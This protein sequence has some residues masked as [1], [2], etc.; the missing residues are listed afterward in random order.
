LNTRQS[1]A[2]RIGA[3]ALI[4]LT[5]LEILWHAWLAP[6]SPAQTWPSLALAIVPLLPGLLYFRHNLRRG[7]LV[8]GIVCLFYFCHGVSVAYDDPALRL[9]ALAEVALALVV[10]GAL[11]WDARRG[12]RA[13]R[14][15]N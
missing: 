11:G 5:A 8:G 15:E 1:A 14:A 9:A 2:L 4:L 13:P 3:C 6:P 12:K 10:I 7:V